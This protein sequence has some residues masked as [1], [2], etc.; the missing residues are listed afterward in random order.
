MRRWTAPANP[1]QCQYCGVLEGD[2]HLKWCATLRYR[3]WNRCFGPTWQYPGES[4]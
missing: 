3:M 1:V 4:W 2:V